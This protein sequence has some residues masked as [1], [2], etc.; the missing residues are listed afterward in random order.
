MQNIADA[1]IHIRFSRYADIERMLDDISTV[2]VT[3][4]ALMSLPYRGAAEN[5]AVL[6]AK[7]RYKKMDVRSFGGIHL[8]D[9]YAAYK[10]EVTAGKLLDMGCDGFKIMYSPDIARFFKFSLDDK[11][12]D[13]LFSLLEERNAPVNIHVADPETFW[14]DPN[15]YGHV[16]FPSKQSMYD[17]VEN[18]LKRHKKLR[19][20]FAHFYFLS[21]MPEEAV[22]IMETYPNVYFDLTPGVEMYRNF[23]NNLD[24][25]REFFPKYKHRIIFG[26]DSNTIKK[27]NKELELLVYRKLTESTGLFTQN[28]YGR[29]LTVRGLALDD[30]TVDCICRRN[31]IDFIGE[32]PAAV[33]SNAVKECAERILFD[34]E[35]EPYDPWY[36]AG[37]EII[38]DLKKDPEQNTVREVC[39]RI[40]AG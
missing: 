36:I 23:D 13:A 2:G 7:S 33:D 21:K 17:S 28:C 39:R 19:V 32:K 4:A 22:R 34:L 15:K 24:F 10:P 14:D 20:V 35:H 11:R 29:D 9:R 5:L 30:D 18:V 38:P 31:F 26:T 27:C 16:S 3:R 8:T 6:D 25:W 40:I 1:H 37:G 12:F